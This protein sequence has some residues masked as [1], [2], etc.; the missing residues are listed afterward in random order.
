MTPRPIRAAARRAL[1]WAL[2]LLAALSGL[3]AHAADTSAAQQLQHWSA[4]ADQPGDAAAGR[5]F[6]TGRHGG[7]WS[8]ASCHGNPPTANGRHESTGKTIA[9]L[10]PAFNPKAF[11]DSAKVDKWFRRNCRD[12]L[13]RE[14]S[15]QEKADVLAFLQG[16]KP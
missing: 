11:T 5:V 4:Q 16:F 6:F 13:Q 2:A 15:A 1:P 14:C 7:E 12:V 10:A 8:C 3:A 9:P